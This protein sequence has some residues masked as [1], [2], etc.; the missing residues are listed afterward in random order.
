MQPE[1]VED[2][3]TENNRDFVASLARGLEVIK[4]FDRQSPTMT[5]SDLARKTGLTRAAARRFLLTLEKLG[6]V[7]SDCKRFELTAKV[8]ELGY[9]YLSSLALSDLAAPFM[10]EIVREVQESCSASV[11]AGEEIVYIARIPTSRIM[12]VTLDIGTKLP[13]YCTS[14]GRV[15]LAALP[16]DQLRELL[17]RAKISKL[18]AHTVTDRGELLRIITKVRENGYSV[19][20]QELELGLRSIAV[21][22]RD[23]RGTVRAA[24]NIS[25]HTSRA[26]PK[27]LTGRY[28]SILNG[29][30]DKISKILP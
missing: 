12:S 22:L 9:A 3:E 16:D 13:A 24:V 5:L 26:T 11:L 10:E 6:Y 28:L 2:D 19:V 4:A 14:M 18:T 23:R 30:A 21:P 25:A 8:L 15:L 17:N 27:D 20:D 1:L 7:R 29:A